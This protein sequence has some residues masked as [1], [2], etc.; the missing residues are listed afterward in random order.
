MQVA[1]LKRVAARE[2]LR[3]GIAQ[4]NLT[5]RGQRTTTNGLITIASVM[6][7]WLVLV[8]KELEEDKHGGRYN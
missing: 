7:L 2:A 8:E 5:F 3:A 4:V 1:G 6:V